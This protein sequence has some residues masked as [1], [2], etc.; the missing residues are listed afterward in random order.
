M[1]KE[2]FKWYGRRDFVFVVVAGLG[3]FHLLR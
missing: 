1:L 3:A 2:V